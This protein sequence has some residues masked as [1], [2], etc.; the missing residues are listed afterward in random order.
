MAE[1][2]LVIDTTTT[3]KDELLARLKQHP[4]VS[5][6]ADDGSYD[7]DPSLSRLVVTTELNEYEMDAWLY[8]QRGVDYIGVTEAA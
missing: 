5:A 6:A 8:E 7:E 1:K 4:N 3:S 2:K